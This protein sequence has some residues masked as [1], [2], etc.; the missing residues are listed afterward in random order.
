MSSLF[1][2]LYYNNNSKYDCNILFIFQEMKKKILK[3]DIRR[4][5]PRILI[6]III[7]KNRYG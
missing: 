5:S 1:R 7:I 3:S 2:C 4:I 6:L